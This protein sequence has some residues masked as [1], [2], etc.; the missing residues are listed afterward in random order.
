METEYQLEIRRLQDELSKERARRQETVSNYDL[1]V[2]KIRDYKKKIE[3]YEKIIK[4]QNQTIVTLTAALND[5][6]KGRI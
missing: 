4:E 5:K 3:T 1:L 2:P 6:E